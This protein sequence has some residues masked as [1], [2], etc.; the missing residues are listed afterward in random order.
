MYCKYNDTNVPI[1]QS[2]IIMIIV[3][4][5]VLHAFIIV[6]QGTVKKLVT[7]AFIQ[8]KIKNVK[9]KDAQVVPTLVL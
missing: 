8:T 5:V 7:L 1:E 9:E 6:N 3:V 4:T 2:K